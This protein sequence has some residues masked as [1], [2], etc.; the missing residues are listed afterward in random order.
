MAQGQHQYAIRVE[1]TGNLGDGTSGYRAYERA[2]EISAPGKPVISGSSDAAFRGDPTRYNPEDLLVSS[3]SAC[4]MLV[5][6]HLCADA[7]ITVTGYVDDAAGTMVEDATIGGRFTEVILRPSVTVRAETDTGEAMRLHERAH[8]LC[9]IANSVNFP[10]CC[11][12]RV[13]AEAV[14]R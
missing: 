11:E 1:W 9:F 4:H 8:Q 5:Y 7:G 6:L 2:H 3:L 10:V 12:A 13:K 14:Q